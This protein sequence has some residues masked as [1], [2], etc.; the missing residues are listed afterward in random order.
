MPE[1]PHAWIEEES[2]IIT[3]I[4]DRDE[5]RNAISRDITAT[6]WRALER[7]AEQDTLRCMII[8][9]EGSHFSA[10][11]DLNEI[12]TEDGRASTDSLRAGWHLRRHYRKHHDLY[13][14]FEAT[15]KPIILAAQGPCLGAGFEMAMSCDFRFCTPSADWCLPEIAIGVIAGSGGSSR[16]TR[17]VGPAWAKY[18]AMAGMRIPAERAHAIGLVHDVFPEMSFRQ[19]VRAF[20]AQLI[21]LPQEAVGLAK[22]AVDL[23]ADFDSR[24]AQRHLDRIVN[25]IL[26]TSREHGAL[27]S[28]FLR[29]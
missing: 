23:A 13:D 24:D 29:K 1:R 20:C 14:A 3:V 18:L 2:G 22:L 15:E 17:L 25:S 4:L 11:I 6:L 26:I 12:P 16:L 27:V 5:K 9:A 7:L 19:D 21:T 10:G 28:K 8:E